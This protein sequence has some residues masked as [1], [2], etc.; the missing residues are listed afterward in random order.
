MTI[1]TSKINCLKKNFENVPYLF[2]SPSLESIVRISEFRR[3]SNIKFPLW[4]KITLFEDSNQNISKMGSFC[5]FL[6]FY[7]TDN[8]WE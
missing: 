2:S 4:N 8:N 6:I 5:Y 3:K 1:T 7:Q